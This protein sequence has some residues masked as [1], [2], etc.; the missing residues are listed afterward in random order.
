MRRIYIWMMIV[1]SHKPWRMSVILVH[2]FVVSL[3]PSRLQP[4]SEEHQQSL[5]SSQSAAE[6][7][8]RYLIF[9]S[10]KAVSLQE[11]I[12]HITESIIDRKWCTYD[13][14]TYRS[15]VMHNKWSRID[16]RWWIIWHDHI[17]RMYIIWHT[18]LLY[19]IYMSHITAT[20]ECIWVNYCI[21][22]LCDKIIWCITYD[23]CVILSYDAS[24]MI[25]VWSYNMMPHQLILEHIRDIFQ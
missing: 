21:W 7:S 10:G 13:M 19:V 9:R 22:E 5:S 16:P 24:H 6:S 12:H 8:V 11:A 18:E 2:T 23:R 3:L 20:T 1:H 15:Q 4:I 25:D 14:I 17:E